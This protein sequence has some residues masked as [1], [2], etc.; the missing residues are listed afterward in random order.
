ML[1]LAEGLT[2]IDTHRVLFSELKPTGMGLETACKTIAPPACEIYMPNP[3]PV[4]ALFLLAFTGRRTKSWCGGRRWERPPWLPCRLVPFDGSSTGH[5]VGP[6]PAE[7]TA[8]VWTPDGKWMYFAADAE[9]GTGKGFHIWR[10]RVGGSMPEQVTFGPTE[11]Q[12]LA[13]APDGKSIYTSSGNTQASVWV[14]DAKGDRRISGEGTPS[15]PVLSRDGT[16]AYYLAVPP[17]SEAA[18]FPSAKL[19]FRRAT[20]PSRRR[21]A[22]LNVADLRTG[23]ASLCCRT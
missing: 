19:I 10:Q 7:C 1:N 11:Q 5:R 15:K 16:K 20:S 4:R 23:E 2:W 22:T 8:A 17:S 6:D 21:A 3:K 13:M 14:H 18:T 9:R 12:G